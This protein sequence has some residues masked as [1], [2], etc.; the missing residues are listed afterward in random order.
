MVTF[1]SPSFLAR[2]D[3]S[4]LIYPCSILPSRARRL[5]RTCGSSVTSRTSAQTRRPLPVVRTSC[6]AACDLS[7]FALGL[8][9]RLLHACCDGIHRCHSATH[10]AARPHAIACRAVTEASVGEWLKVQS[11][12]RSCG[13]R[14]RLVPPHSGS[15][16]TRT[17]VCGMELQPLTAALL[18][19]GSTVRQVLRR[20]TAVQ[21]G[22]S[23]G[24]PRRHSALL[25]A[26]Q[27][28]RWHSSSHRRQQQ[29]AAI[30]TCCD[31]T[32]NH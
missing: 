6:I 1:V 2:S 23:A 27:F 31:R 7:Y 11:S 17:C 10:L 3:D 30:P 21:V 8:L 26:S 25:F 12:L 14:P 22:T 29:S 9:S 20:G 15:S 16:H 28:R 4:L 5:D 13:T 24:N 32:F 18:N 19:G